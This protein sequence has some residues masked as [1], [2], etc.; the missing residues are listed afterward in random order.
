MGPDCQYMHIKKPESQVI[1][2]NI[3]PKYEFRSLRKF[4]IGISQKWLI[5]FKMSR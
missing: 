4:Q 3:K 5:T 2:K 1:L